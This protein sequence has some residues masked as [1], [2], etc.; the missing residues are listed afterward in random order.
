MESVGSLK[1]AVFGNPILHSKSPQIFNSFFAASGKEAFY[2]RIRPL[3]CADIPTIIRSLAIAGA[4][5]TT[6][7]KEEIIPL[8]DSISH[9]AKIINGVNTIINRNGKLTGHNTDYLGVVHAIE[10]EGFSI[11]G[12]RSLVIGAGPA[13]RAAVYGMHLSGSKVTI[14]NRTLEK[15]QQM[16]NMFH[17]NVLSLDEMKEKLESF[18]FIISST[19][20]EGNP[21][22]K[23]KIPKKTVVLD[24]NYR[25]TNL[26]KMSEI[27]GFTLIS[28][29]SWLLGQAQSAIEL[30]FNTKVDLAILKMQF[31]D[32]PN[33]TQLNVKQYD[34]TIDIP[35]FRSIDLIIGGDG[36][37]K[38]MF[39]TLLN[40]EV[41]LVKTI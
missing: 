35:S 10:Q 12:S 13:G 6:P 15:A 34:K 5:I 27:E 14:A 39:N 36:C 38:L 26:L 24:A 40:Q 16:A 18:D 41:S 1:F 22:L 21:L 4:N 25:D 3:Q 29:E 33:F 9:E 11:K 31:D 19:S 8:L 32:S 28:G 37:I 17:C 2:T 7:F 23:R 20:P 30:F